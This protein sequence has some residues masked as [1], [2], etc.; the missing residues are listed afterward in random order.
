[1]LEPGSD[2]LLTLVAPGREFTEHY[3]YHDVETN[4]GKTTLITYLYLGDIKNSKK[5]TWRRHK[6]REVRR[7]DKG[8][9]KR[10]RG[11]TMGTAPMFVHR[12]WF[13]HLGFDV[14]EED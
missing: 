6:V 4:E 3:T 14:M 7:I 9:G 12:A 8:T 13:K 1:M 10:A 5:H 2:A 11:N